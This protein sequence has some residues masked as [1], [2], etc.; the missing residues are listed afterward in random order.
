MAVTQH[1]TS[2]CSFGRS[3]QNLNNN[4]QY[5]LSNE[6]S[7]DKLKALSEWQRVRI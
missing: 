4:V 2:L 3:E 1:G 5:R 7:I 6:F